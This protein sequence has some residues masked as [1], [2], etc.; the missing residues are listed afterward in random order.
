MVKLL[1]IYFRVTNSNL[2]NIK[3]PFELLTN[4]RFI[5]D[6]QFYLFQFCLCLYHSDAEYDSFFEMPNS[7]WPLKLISKILWLFVIHKFMLRCQSDRIDVFNGDLCNLFG[8]KCMYIK[9]TLQYCRLSERAKGIMKTA[10]RV[11]KGFMIFCKHVLR[12]SD[13]FRGHSK[14]TPAW[15]KLI[16]LTIWSI[17]PIQIRKIYEH[18]LKRAKT[19]T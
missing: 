10:N 19:F 17:L 18:I 7:L 8:E 3:L 15:N 6:I 16:F 9:S 12:F 1:F 13:V 14:R 5:L 11:E 2:K 4:S